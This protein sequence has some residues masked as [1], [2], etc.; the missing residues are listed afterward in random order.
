MHELKPLS[1]NPSFLSL[2][3]LLEPEIP[4]WVA[5]EQPITVRLPLKSQH[6]LAYHQD[7]CQHDLVVQLQCVS[8]DMAD[9]GE[10]L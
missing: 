8:R 1:R 6:N 7:V 4:S 10:V 9:G 5:M 2:P 3:S